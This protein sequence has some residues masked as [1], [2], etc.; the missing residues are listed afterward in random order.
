[1]ELSKEEVELID[2]Y[3][4]WARLLPECDTLSG[5]WV[6]D[7][8]GS[9]RDTISLDIYLV[10]LRAYLKPLRQTVKLRQQHFEKFI[11]G[12]RYED[13]PHRHWRLEMN[14][15]LEDAEKKYQKWKL[16]KESMILPPKKDKDEYIPDL[17][18]TS[19]NKNKNPFESLYLE[20]SIMPHDKCVEIVL[21]PKLSSKEK[22]RR[23]RLRHRYKQRQKQFEQ[24]LFE[25]VEES[26][27]P[28]G[29]LSC[30]SDLPLRAVMT[31]SPKN[32]NYPSIIVC[33][34][35]FFLLSEDVT[36]IAEKRE[37]L[38]HFMLDV[39]IKA[40]PT[41]IET[42]R[43][44]EQQLNLP[45]PRRGIYISDD[46]PISEVTNSIISLILNPK[47]LMAS[48]FGKP[49]S[50]EYSHLIFTLSVLTHSILMK[51]CMTAQVE[52]YFTT[53]V[54]L[55]RSGAYT[56]E[57]CSS[58]ARYFSE[59]IGLFLASIYSR[60]EVP[61]VF[62]EAPILLRL[63]ADGL[64]LP[65]L[66]EIKKNLEGRFLFQLYWLLDVHEARSVSFNFMVVYARVTRSY[67]PSKQYRFFMEVIERKMASHLSSTYEFIRNG[68]IHV[69]SDL[70]DELGISNTG[71]DLN[72]IVNR[73]LR[74]TGQYKHYWSNISRLRKNLDL[75]RRRLEE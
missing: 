55:T 56:P 67:L 8:G 3:K 22:K 61:T 21:P 25:T 9:I 31:I 45:P 69:Y 18:L 68:H 47:I 73:I 5:Y 19:P 33:S 17:T 54:K 35:P 42:I 4:T 37:K 36:L 66:E 24:D 52:K 63:L 53:L 38:L 40:T 75:L 51:A 27:K 34:Y 41:N 16:A 70:C 10:S 44:K 13:P 72:K 46:I 62:L 26:Q 57:E 59:S 50:I 74:A 11:R 30:V 39:Q 58:K 43:R 29:S 23:K 71:V 49:G 28:L 14:K 20:P 2:E 48:P 64:P 7:Y 15:I 32:I 6:T 1:M 65:S 12:K 60:S